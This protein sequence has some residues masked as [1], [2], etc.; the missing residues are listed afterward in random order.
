MAH[1][2]ALPES[3]EMLR[4]LRAMQFLTVLIEQTPARLAAEREQLA[5]TLSDAIRSLE[6]VHQAG[7]AHHQQLEARLSK[8]PEEIAKGISADAIAA[9]LNERLRQQLQES[10]LAGIA[11][12]MGV[13]AA[14]LRKA[15]KELSTA[16]DEFSHPRYGAV[17]VV[18]SALASMKANTDN[19][20][21]HIR[22][23]MNGLGKE[24]H[25]TIAVLFAA[26]IALGFVMGIGYYRWITSPI[27]PAELSPAVQKPAQQPGA[28][29]KPDRRKFSPK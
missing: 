28:A 1:C 12:T 21:D 20:A 14:G 4:I 29:I 19:A 3:D 23:Q 5:T 24:L 16:L 7:I 6:S 17:S 8:L 13:Q 11:E 22:T 2:R 15:S 26:A 18:N 27:D 10:G 25:R 9:K